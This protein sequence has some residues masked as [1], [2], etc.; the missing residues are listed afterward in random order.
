MIERGIERVRVGERRKTTLRFLA[1]VGVLNV[2]YLVGYIIP[3]EFLR[4]RAVR[5]RR[6]PR[7]GRTSPTASAVR[8]RPSCGV[9]DGPI[10]TGTNSIHLDPNGRLIVPQGA[11]L[12]TLVRHAR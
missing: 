1:L 10:P 3:M 2:I 11:T 12:P 9:A 7:A 4:S 5:G 8:A 6:R